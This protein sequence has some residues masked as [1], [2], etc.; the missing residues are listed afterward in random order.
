[1]VSLLAIADGEAEL[2]TR[3]ADAGREFISLGI[4]C[5]CLRIII[6]FVMVIYNTTAMIICSMATIM[7]MSSQVSTTM[8]VFGPADMTAGAILHFV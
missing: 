7:V 3:I 5:L 1:M 4:L 8:V 6:V 2:P